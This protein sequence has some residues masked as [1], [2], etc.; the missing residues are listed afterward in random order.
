MPK[1]R[2]PSRA[3]F[4]VFVQHSM[5]LGRYRATTRFHDMSLKIIFD[6]IIPLDFNGIA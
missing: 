5:R 3:T 1:M 4:H 6:D 2:S